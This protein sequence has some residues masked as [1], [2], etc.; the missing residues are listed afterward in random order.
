MAADAAPL[1]AAVARLPGG[2]LPYVV[3]RH[4]RSR[5]LRVTIDPVRGLIVSVPPA[6]RRGWA[7]PEAAIEQFLAEREPW[8]RRHL[9]R[10][11]EARTRLE[12]RRTATGGTSL[13]YRG[14]LHRVRL[15][16]AGPGARRSRVSR[17]GAEDRD[18][19]VVVVAAGDRRAP[20]LVLEAWLRERAR[21]A[22][23]R[24]IGTHAP[25]LGVR[26]TA[27]AIRDPRSRW[28]SATPAGRVMF[29]WRLV[30]GPPDALD[31][32][33]VHELAHLRVMGHGPAFWG[34]VAASR[35]DHRTWRACLRTHSL[36]LHE[37][38]PDPRDGAVRRST[39]GPRHGGAAAGAAR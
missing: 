31:T 28:G 39:A 22:I 13:R 9:A 17:I 4:P 5:H 38:L 33:V 15:E 11:A 37:A 24:A 27:V 30:L 23:D 25:V 8:I 20:T 18:E 2:P 26:P 12:D 32:V 35:P 10:Q 34:L 1:E 3:R 19:L 36:E 21:E 6:S 7:R 14:E 16:P 29:S